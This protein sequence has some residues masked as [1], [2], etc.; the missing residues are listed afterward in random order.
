MQTYRVRYDR[1][2]YGSWQFGIVRTSERLPVVS[3]IHDTDN[4]YSVYA[5][6]RVAAQLC[7]EM[8]K[9]A[10]DTWHDGEEAT[11]TQGPPPAPSAPPAPP[12][13]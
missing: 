9:E 7:A 10:P 12:S 1:G 13:K 5:A 6:E 3:N 8:N 2:Y 4:P 11:I